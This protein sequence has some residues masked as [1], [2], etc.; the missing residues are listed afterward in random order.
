MLERLENTSSAPFSGAELARL[1]NDFP[2][3]TV[4]GRSG[5]PIAYFD[6]AATSQK[7]QCVIDSLVQ[8]YG[9][10]NAAV[11]RGTH[12]LGDLA[13]TEFEN[14]REAVAH[15]LGAQPEGLIWTKN[16]TEALNLLAY[17]LSAPQSTARTA[18]FKPLGPGD[19]IC[20]TRL[21]HHANL[22]PW[23][24][25]CKRTGAK[26]T[27][28]EATEDGRLDPQNFERINERTRILAF[29]H[30]SNVTGA[31]SPVADLV[32]RAKAVGAVT[33]LDSCQSTAHGPFNFRELDVDFAVA[34]SHKMLGPTGIGALIARPELVDQLPPFL[35]GGAMVTWVEM[36]SATF[37]EGPAGFEAGSQPVAQAVGWARACE[38]LQL[39]GPERI[40]AHEHALGEELLAG[41]LE[42]PGLRLLGPTTMEQRAAVFAFA[43]PGIH[44]HDVGQLLDSKDV[45]VRVGHHC[46]IPLHQHFG[47]RS[48]ARASVS[49]TNTSAEVDRLLA[50]IVETQRFFGGTNV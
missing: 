20:I 33:V 30:V 21:E 47:V 19:E 18:G 40:A 1:R 41:L 45:A 13:T 23:Q 27:W 11:N 4:P 35:T 3:L 42:I 17:S 24:E 14:A 37:H 39:V 26:L 31:L 9:G 46:A 10:Q 22:V 2:I 16:A 8:F 7:P 29:T 25:A 32:A 6:A 12:L 15:Y 48:S 43:L 49:L 28:L 44:P 36:D 5:E 38:Y 34:S 50:A